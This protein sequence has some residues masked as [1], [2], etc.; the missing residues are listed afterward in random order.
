[1]AA[2]STGAPTLLDFKKSL[3][4]N[5][6][7]ARVIEQ[8]AQRND[9]LQDMPFME[10]NL[11]VGHQTTIRTGLPTPAWRLLNAGIQ[12]TKATTAQVT[13]QCGMLESYS[14]VDVALADLNGN[15]GAF[16]AAQARPHYEAM[17]QEAAATIFYGAATAQEEFVGLVP[18]Y[19]V[20]SGAPISSNVISA[21]G[22]DAADQ[23]S[24]W[25]I[26]WHSEGITGIY[27]KGSQAGIKHTDKGVQT[28]YGAT[29]IGGSMFEAYVEHWVW[30]L[31]LCVADWR[32]AVRI[33]NIDVSNITAN[34]SVADLVDHMEHAC[35][36]IH[37]L[38]FGKAV[39]YM[40]RTA[41]RA[42]DRLARADVSAGGQLDYNVVDGKRLTSF[43]GVPIHICD[44]ILNSE[45]VVS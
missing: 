1:M 12:P 6:A 26:V 36:K 17:A 24:I 2:L 10:G 38:D 25:L 13:E 30:K 33:C 21:G 4:P 7:I 15:A 40:N 9:I 11:E 3:D 27:P 29:G 42:L 16:R 14:Q 18:R 41:K 34:S 31:G 5:G 20:L 44:A 28:V 43:Q 35:S 8:L 37:S 32:Q 23:T 45:D 39:F 19:S 22:S